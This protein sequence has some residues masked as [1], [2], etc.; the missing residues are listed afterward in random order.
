MRSQL[1]GLSVVAALAGAIFAGA[2]HAGT[3]TKFKLFDH[4]DAGAAPPPY[5]IRLDNLFGTDSGDGGVTTFS[6][7][8]TEGVFLTVTDNTDMGGGITINISGVVFG[9]RDTGSTVDSDHDGTGTYQLDFTYT[10]NVGEQGTG[11]VVNPAS[12]SNAGTLEA[13]NVNGDESDFMFSIFESTGS[14]NFKFLQDDHRLN[15]HPESGQGFWVGR[16]WLT[17]DPLTN[18]SGTQDFLFIG[19]LVPLPTPGALTAAGLLTAA[20]VRRRRA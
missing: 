4:P 7:N 1:T 3:V 5:G 13:I 8:T 19:M 11:W 10:V 14:N 12:A 2:A 16:G 20:L 17:F 6:F 15:G 9:G 18:A